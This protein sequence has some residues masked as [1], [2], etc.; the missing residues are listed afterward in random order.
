[1]RQQHETLKSVK[2]QENTRVSLIKSNTHKLT[3]MHTKQTLNQLQTP[4]I[5][6]LK[7][8]IQNK[9]L[10]ANIVQRI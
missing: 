4:R 7:L 1:M 8:I 9:K 10:H 2:F 5:P 3:Q 6:K